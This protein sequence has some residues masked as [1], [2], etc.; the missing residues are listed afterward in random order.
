MK[1]RIT[2]MVVGL[3]VAVL[4]TALWVVGVTKEASGWESSCPSYCGFY[5]DS[6]WI[7]CSHPGC[8]GTPYE[9]GHCTCYVYQ[10]A[11]GDGWPTDYLRELGNAGQW[12][13]KARDE[14]TTPPYTRPALPV[15]EY[16]YL[17]SIAV[18]NW[19]AGHVAY[20]T[21]RWYIGNGDVQFRVDEMNPCEQRWDGAWPCT[22][23]VRQGV[24]Q[25]RDSARY[26]FIY[27][28]ADGAVLVFPVL[29]SIRPEENPLPLVWYSYNGGPYELEMRLF[30]I[31]YA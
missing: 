15:G 28:P 21:G 30:T 6:Q 8:Y 7:S 2:L 20:V 4:V 9:N 26:S 19:G 23:C 16:P 14:D 27:P 11:T 31:P 12:D 29:E 3:L 13:D 22:H 1:R 17:R 18:D 10:V 24:V 25:N 5:Q